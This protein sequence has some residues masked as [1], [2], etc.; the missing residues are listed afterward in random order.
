MRGRIFRSRRFLIS[1]RFAGS[2]FGGN[3]IPVKLVPAKA[4]SRNL[5]FVAFYFLCALRG[6]IIF[7]FVHSILFRIRLSERLSFGVSK[8]DFRIC[9]IVRFEQFAQ[10][11]RKKVFKKEFRVFVS[12]SRHKNLVGLNRLACSLGF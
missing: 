1:L 4:G 6:Y 10:G 12:R 11:G 3:L 8:F 9:K 7:D 5:F 2:V